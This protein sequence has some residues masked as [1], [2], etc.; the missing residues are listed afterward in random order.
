MNTIV[1][2]AREIL[3]SAVENAGY[4]IVDIDF[5]KSYGED[6]LTIYIFKKGGVSLD[7]CEKVNNL[8][9]PILEENDLTDGKPYNLNISSPGLDRPVVSPDDYRRSLDTELEIV[10]I[11]PIGKKKKANGILLSYD[12]ETLTLKVKDKEV[13]FN[14]NNAKVVR[15]YIKF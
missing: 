2:K 15:P 5:A 13:K 3:T 4:E 9:D 12:E 8:L 11:E 7:D 6:N 14:K 10:F 1:E